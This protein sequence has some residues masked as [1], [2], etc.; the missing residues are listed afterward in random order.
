MGST[1]SPRRAEGNRRTHARDGTG[2]EREE[3]KKRAAAAA[4]AGG[5]SAPPPYRR[6]AAP[7]KGKGEPVRLRLRERERERDRGERSAGAHLP[8]PPPSPCRPAVPL[9][10]LCAGRLCSA[11][12]CCWSEPRHHQPRRCAPSQASSPRRPTTHPL[13]LLSLPVDLLRLA[14]AAHHPSLPP[15]HLRW[16]ACLPA[17][18]PCLYINASQPPLRLLRP[19]HRTFQNPPPSP[20]LSSPTDDSDGRRRGRRRRGPRRAA[21]P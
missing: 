14:I 3:R 16:D 6:G 9:L 1:R 13:H 18:L 8:P 7:K 11:L 12:L 21:A 15:I 5:S 10:L 2:R 4:A 19:R 20:P 17:C